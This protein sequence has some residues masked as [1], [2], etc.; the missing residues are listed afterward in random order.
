MLLRNFES[1]NCC[2][3]LLFTNQLLKV[4]SRKQKKLASLCS[5]YSEYTYADWYIYTFITD[6]KRSTKAL[7]CLYTDDFA[8]SCSLLL[9]FL[10][11]LSMEKRF[12]SLNFVPLFH[13]TMIETIK[14]ELI[15]INASDKSLIYGKF[16]F[17]SW[18]NK[19][20]IMKLIFFSI[21]GWNNG[22]IFLPD[23]KT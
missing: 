14:L 10:P 18:A 2:S 5:R 4:W 3:E 7:F 1:I 20:N 22:K 13:S 21:L 19:K 11:R 23:F 6:A 12:L 17:S 9:L 15:Q 16:Q 8:S